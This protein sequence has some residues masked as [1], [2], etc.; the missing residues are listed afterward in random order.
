MAIQVE[1]WRP[2]IKSA[3][4]MPMG[5]FRQGV[6]DKPAD[7][8]GVNEAV[9]KSWSDNAPAIGRMAK[10]IE[11][12]K[13]I[14]ANITHD[15]LNNVAKGQ[16]EVIPKT[17]SDAHA[18]YPEYLEDGVTKHPRAGQPKDWA[19][20][21]RQERKKL[22]K[23]IESLGVYKE[24]I[25]KLITSFGTDVSLNE[26]NIDYH[27]LMKNPDVAGFLSVL[28]E[29]IELDENGQPVGDLSWGF[30]FEG[31]HS[32]TWNEIMGM[33]SGK[34]KRQAKQSYKN[35]VEVPRIW[36]AT[37]EGENRKK[38]YITLGQ[39][40]AA[41]EMFKSNAGTKGTITIDL[42]A[43]AKE[44]TAEINQWKKKTGGKDT[45]EVD[46]QGNAIFKDEGMSV[47]DQN[48]KVLEVSRTKAQSII[49]QYGP[50][51]IY[52]NMVP[53]KADGTLALKDDGTFDLAVGKTSGRY[54]EKYNPE[55]HAAIVE[56]YVARAIGN[57][58]MTP[59]QQE[60]TAPTVPEPG[61]PPSQYPKTVVGQISEQFAGISNTID[62]GASSEGG[63]VGK[64]I[65]TS[66]GK[67]YIEEY[68]IKKG[69]DGQVLLTLSYRG[70]G[71]I[72]GD[73]LYR[74]EDDKDVPIMIDTGKK[75]PQGNAILK[76]MTTED[77]DEGF[78]LPTFDLTKIGD[79]KEL[80]DAL[81]VQA[82]ARKDDYLDE[83]GGW[84]IA[85]TNFIL[86]DGNIKSI[87]QND[88]RQKVKGKEGGTNHE[89]W[90]DLINVSPY[91]RAQV[92]KRL[93]RM[94]NL[95]KKEQAYQANLLV[96]EKRY[97]DNKK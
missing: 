80:Y 72:K 62:E 18:P 38:N 33:K 59:M 95:T 35:Q 96:R 60:T 19:D 73:K 15:Y 78:D 57:E 34:A 4:D 22:N 61:D 47:A 32:Q 75:D 48:T 40:H 39:L 88:M 36:Y 97:Q 29:E 56:E 9:Q 76:Q 74:R 51:W 14:K 26:E 8:A 55:K 44:L 66:D 20:M 54:K 92:I 89:S 6:V 49:N 63:L 82:D 83:G 23:Q 79:V 69:E 12:E 1:Q 65:Q 3:P 27:A 50:A 81:G 68:D 5:P 45:G 52:S 71:I 2:N 21:N 30:D 53:I 93:K 42:N 84:S 85:R 17:I 77:Q 24:Q 10:M 7:W 46:S 58:S 86:N 90:Q 28:G 16:N 67:K 87:I 13:D 64:M 94:T 41:Q 70:S 11:A 43:S 25:Q 31:G 37:G 91:Y